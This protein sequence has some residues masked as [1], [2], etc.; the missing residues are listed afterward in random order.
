LTETA[1]KTPDVAQLGRQRDTTLEAL[2]LAAPR[3]YQAVLRSKIRLAQQRRED[4]A[5][6][7]FAKACDEHGPEFNYVVGDTVSAVFKIAEAASMEVMEVCF[8]VGV[9][10][11]AE[12]AAFVAADLKAFINSFTR[13]RFFVSRPGISPS[14]C[15]QVL[16][17][18]AE[19]A[20]KASARTPDQVVSFRH[21]FK[22]KQGTLVDRVLVR[23]KDHPILGGGVIAAI[24]FLAAAQGVEIVI[25]LYQHLMN[26]LQSP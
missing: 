14:W 23:T 24:I 11:D 5:T 12:I 21:D 8:D 1:P 15:L 16:R 4:P 7:A 3:R 17:E 20:D 6:A 25:G 18:I 10:G 26:L 2:V 19:M 13:E 9:S 22:R